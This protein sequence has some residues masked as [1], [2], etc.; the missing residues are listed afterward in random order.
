MKCGSGHT[1]I[2]RLLP[3]P[4]LFNLFICL[5][6]T[7]FSVN[8]S[9]VELDDLKILFH[10]RWGAHFFCAVGIPDS[11]SSLTRKSVP[12]YGTNTTLVDGPQLLS[13]AVQAG[14][15]GG[16]DALL[17]FSTHDGTTRTLPV[18]LH[19]QPL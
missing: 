16:T 3:L 15:A 6:C 7:R 11:G 9:G 12:P 2:D 10:T 1:S 8:A 19:G 4:E 14:D 17:S 18:R 5:V 13:L